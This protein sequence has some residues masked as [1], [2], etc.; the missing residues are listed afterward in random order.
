MPST[1]PPRTLRLAGSLLAAGLALGSLGA[2]SFSSD[3]VSCSGTSCSVTLSGDGA[4]ADV[5]GNTLTLSGIKDGTA[6]LGAGG[7]SVSCTQ[8]Q[9]VTAGPLHLTCSKITSDAVTLT[10]SVG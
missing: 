10:A 6:T 7:A 1:T 8:G 5:L 9:S 3:N 2:C 4:K